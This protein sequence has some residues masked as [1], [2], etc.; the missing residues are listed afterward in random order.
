MRLFAVTVSFLFYQL[1]EFSKNLYY[2]SFADIF[3]FLFSYGF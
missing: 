1:N 2:F 3:L